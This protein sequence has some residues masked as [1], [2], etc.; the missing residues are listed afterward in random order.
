[1]TT[2]KPPHKSE[3]AKSKNQPGQILM[4]WKT[5]GLSDKGA[6]SVEYEEALKEVRAGVDEAISR[7]KIPPGYHDVIKKYFSS[8]SGEAIATEKN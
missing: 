8:D 7:E 4:Q 5:K 3:K 2:L 6:V 1:M